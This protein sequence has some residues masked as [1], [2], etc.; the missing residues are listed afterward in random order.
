M[1]RVL[2]AAKLSIVVLVL[3]CGGRQSSSRTAP[4]EDAPVAPELLAALDRSTVPQS[5]AH[6]PNETEP[7]VAE[8]PADWPFCPLSASEKSLRAAPPK[9]R[10]NRCTTEA[11]LFAPC[12]SA[13]VVKA[14]LSS[15]C[16]LH[17]GESAYHVGCKGQLEL[18][19]WSEPVRRDLPRT[20][21][22]GEGEPQAG[23]EPYELMVVDLGP[24]VQA[25][26]VKVNERSFEYGG[27]GELRVDVY[28]FDGVKVTSV[29][30]RRTGYHGPMGS[31]EELSFIPRSNQIAD[32][33]IEQL[34]SYENGL[35]RVDY[36]LR[37]ERGEYREIKSSLSD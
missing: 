21:L 6:N 3:G 4:A 37:F 8:P 12:T 7:A 23:L 2:D 18:T 33:S 16:R 20:T 11:V 9:L 36:L 5:V 15:C 35:D 24:A 31:H 28:V 14:T 22:E 29:V 27:S 17:T 25:V 1:L 13:P 30:T 32:L 34:T 10:G 26:L 19:G